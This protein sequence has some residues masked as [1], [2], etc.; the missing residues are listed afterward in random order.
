MNIVTAEVRHN[1]TGAV[2]CRAQG[3]WNGV[4]EFT[5]SSGETKLMDTHRLPVTRKRMRHVEKQGPL[6]SR[7]VRLWQHVTEAL[8]AGNMDE[9]TENKHHLEERQRNDERQRAASKT[10]WTPKHFTKQ[11]DGWTYSRPLWETH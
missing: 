2:V 3:E 10:P 7:A 5:Y 4:L 8:K 1:H 6:E 9:A 11:G